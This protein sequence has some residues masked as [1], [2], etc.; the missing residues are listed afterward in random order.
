MA[1]RSA[2]ENLRSKLEEGEDS[3]DINIDIEVVVDSDADAAEDIAD[4]T[5]IVENEAEADAVVEADEAAEQEAEDMAEMAAVLRKHGLN[6]GM[7]ALLKVLV[8]LDAYGISMPAYESLDASGRNQ[9][10]AD[11]LAAAF[12]ASDKTF[13]ENTKNFFAKIWQWIADSLTKLWDMLGR[14]NTKI[15][16]TGKSLS[17]R[18]FNADRAKDKKMKVCKGEGDTVSKCNSAAT[19]INKCKGFVDSVAKLT[20]SNI[21][22]LIQLPATTTTT[23][24]SEGFW[25]FDGEGEGQQ[26]KSNPSGSQKKDDKV[27]AEAAKQA[28]TKFKERLKK[29]LPEDDLKL[30]GLKWKNT[31]TD[32]AANLTLDSESSFYDTDDRDI[33]LEDVTDYAKDGKAYTA[34]LGL[35]QAGRNLANAKDDAKK[36]IKNAKRDDEIKNWGKDKDNTD[37]KAAKTAISLKKN[38]LSVLSKIVSACS[39]CTLKLCGVYVA[40]GRKILGCTT[41]K[42]S[43]ADYA[44]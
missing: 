10:Q 40:A 22:T 1:R 37:V 31:G 11:R 14:M 36:Q 44:K 33:K 43:N 13:W 23:S 19:T 35:C 16:R 32:D 42:N 41:S 17:D 25:R 2:F 28:I 5:D 6:A 24:G 29:A 3:G 18:T 38:A 30:I 21:E 7:A 34:A 27:D 20:E 39:K 8:P 9:S 15:I 12:E 26:Q 4:A